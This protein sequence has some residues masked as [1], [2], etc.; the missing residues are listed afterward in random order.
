MKK[1]SVIELIICFIAI[2]SIG[3]YILSIFFVDK[4]IKPNYN[5][6]ELKYYK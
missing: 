5:Y 3:A 2:L 4:M 6:K 1:L